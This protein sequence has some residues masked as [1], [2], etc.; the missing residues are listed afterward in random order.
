[1]HTV[2]V[3]VTAEN[4]YL[5]VVK[6]S[7]THIRIY[8]SD[9]QTG[10]FLEITTAETRIPLQI[11]VLS[12][13]YYDDILPGKW[14]KYEFG[15]ETTTY[16][17]SEAFQFQLGDPDKI[18][19]SFGNYSIPE[20]TFG[21]VLTPDDMKQV[22][23]WG[24]DLVSQDSGYSSWD[25]ERTRFLVE[26]S[27]KDFEKH[28]GIDIYRRKY[29]CLP[30]DTDIKVPLWMD[31][32]S[33]IYTDEEAPYDF[34][35]DLW[36]NYGFL[37]LRRRPIIN[38]SRCYLVGPT[39]AG[40]LDLLNSNWLRIDKEFGQLNAF[41]RNQMIF[42]P[43]TAGYGSILMW[44]MRRYPQGLQIDYET[45]FENAG[46]V[47]SDL[48]EIIGKWCSVKMLNVIGDGILPGFSSQSVSL[49]GLSESFSSTQ[50]ATSAYF[51]ARIKQYTDDIKEWLIRNR[52][53]YSGIP[54]GFVGG[55]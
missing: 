28:L 35:T 6:K 4:L 44:T 26:S 45:G 5:L 19:W 2:K 40:V 23:L 27:V 15:N 16:G 37:K 48:R 46:F 30:G 50:S 17:L 47:P 49:D 29:K 38:I 53:K 21:D 24:I 8:R 12:Y 43:P 13:S 42:A 36:L 31:G 51:G 1:M 33:N 20:G 32:D 41:P 10:T 3:F 54:M 14:Y 9:T 7:L 55:S 39:G 25:D 22:Y 52:Y 18:G 34:D 11:G